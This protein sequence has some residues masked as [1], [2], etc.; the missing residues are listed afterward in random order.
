MSM[1]RH[2]R[3][4]DWRAR[5]RKRLGMPFQASRRTLKGAVARPDSNPRSRAWRFASWSSLVFFEHEGRLHAIT[6]DSLDEA[7][8]RAQSKIQ[9]GRSR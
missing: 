8:E 6:Q 4:D 3:N 2:P 7:F 5:E 1:H 9:A